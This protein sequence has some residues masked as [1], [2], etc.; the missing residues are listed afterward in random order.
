M[1]AAALA[2]AWGH[3]PPPSWHPGGTVP[4]LQGGSGGLAR[5]AGV[6]HGCG[7]SRVC[8]APHI[9]HP[10]VWVPP[11][12]V[13]WGGSTPAVSPPLGA[14][15]R[16]LPLPGDSPCPETPSV[17]VTLLGM[18]M[19]PGH[20]ATPICP[21]QG[22]ELAGVSDNGAVPGPKGQ[23]GPRR[24]KLPPCACQPC[25]HWAGSGTTVCPPRAGPPPWAAA[26]WQFPWDIPV[27]TGHQGG[28]GHCWGVKGS[29]G[30]GPPVPQAVGK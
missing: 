10:R 4:M 2:R 20:G 17:V 9:G 11:E 26:G 6:A 21:L 23:Q 29:Q 7:V 15:A 25:W 18:K 27:G 5:R 8:W 16:R 22:P 13:A 24:A 12:L 28:T 19:S 3:R 1:L 30:E 14:C